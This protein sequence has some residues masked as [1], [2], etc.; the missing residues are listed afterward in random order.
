[1]NR[2]AAILVVLV[3][4]LAAAPA[5]RA[6]VSF[7][8]LFDALVQE[9]DAAC[10]VTPVEAKSVWENGRIYTYTRVH[11]E[12]SFAGGVAAGQDVWVQTMGGEVGD[13]G[14]LV[15]GEAVLRPG[16]TSLVFLKRAPG[17]GF[18]VTA[19]GQGQFP[20]VKDATTH[21]LELMRNAHAGALLA[22]SP[23]ALA[24]I[25][26]ASPGAPSAA[27]PAGD[28]LDGKSLDDAALEIARAW[29][30]THAP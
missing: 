14:Q 15:D 16:K 4:L 30:R 28:V 18:V 11:V 23:A 1:M 22:P 9:S 3:A 10:V 6:S 19:R 24:R 27:L 8:V 2:A 17:S 29:S 5:A 7:T 26:S 21:T 13:I 25:R 12:R 20:V